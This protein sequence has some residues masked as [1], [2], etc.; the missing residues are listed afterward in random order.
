M[1]TLRTL[2]FLTTV[3]IFGATCAFGASGDNYDDMFRPGLAG[4]QYDNDAFTEVDEDGNILH[5]LN[6][7]W[8]SALGNDWRAAWHGYIEGPYTGDVTISAEFED[9]M[10][11]LIDNKVVIDGIRRR[12]RNKMSCTVKMTKGKK[13]PIAIKFVTFNS[14]AFLRL[15]WQWEGSKK[16][17]IPGEALSFQ[18]SSLPPALRFEFAYIGLENALNWNLYA[19]TRAPLPADQIDVS[20]AKIVVLQKGNKV[21]DNGADMLADEILKRARIDVPTVKKTKNEDVCFVIGTKDDLAKNKISLPDG[22]AVPQEKDGYAF[23]VDNSSKAAKVYLI[24]YDKRGALFA[25]GRLLRSLDMGRDWAYL[26]KDIKISTAPKYPLRGHQLGY[27][28]KTNS[29]DGWT[30]EM[31]EQYYRDMIVFGMNAVE[32]V[33][34]VTDDDDDSPLFPKPKMEMMIAMSKLADDY[35]LDVWIWYPIMEFDIDDD[36]QIT[37]ELMQLAIKNRDEVLSKLQR[38]DAVFVPSGDPDEVHPKYL[39]PHM[40]EHKRVLTKYHLNATIWSSVQNYDDEE[41]TMGWIAAFYKWLGRNDIDW[42][43]G[44]VFGPATETT[45]PKMRK[46]VPKKFPIRRYTDITHSK[47]C[48]YRIRDWDMAWQD[49]L[50]R[51]CINPRPVDYTK[52]FRDIQHLSI[53]FISYSEGCNDDF[54][55]ILWSCLGWDPDMKTEDIVAEYSKYFIGS[56]LAEGYAKGIFALEQNW[57]GDIKDTDQPYKTLELFQQLEAEATPHDKLNWRFQQGLYRAYYDAY[58][59]ARY[60][61]EMGL[62]KQALGVL[63]NAPTIGTLAAMD[64]AEAI[65]DKAETEKVRTDLRARTFELAEALFQSIRMQLSVP[66]YKAKQ[67][68]RGANLDAID[69][70]INHSRQIKEMFAEIRKIDS[71]Q[72]RLAKIVIIA[73]DRFEKIEYDWEEI[74]EEQ[75]GITD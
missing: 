43:D 57:R 32:I 26:D 41:K 14:K 4:A 34:P 53:G 58:I 11:L 51:E 31:W 68:S 40:K 25:V 46:A 9:G 6:Q 30:I 42:F 62:K 8:A 59:K 7:N 5:S 39:F 23:W 73:S 47:S 10:E 63:K 18:L 22:L 35:D 17:V 70:P 69:V 67:L 52:I 75:L 60:E 48:Q 29:Y 72:E 15:E 64:Q 21:L 36:E 27:R 74:F 45:L 66:K 49:T 50:G 38:V 37:D 3:L 28:P 65:L 1:K 12:L 54:N 19:P 71:E 13:V 33:P 56:R 44:V 20:T 2:L 61:Y 24:G 55:K 16:V